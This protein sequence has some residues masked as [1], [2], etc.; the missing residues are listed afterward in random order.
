MNTNKLT[1]YLLTPTGLLAVLVLVLSSS[2]IANGQQI[3]GSIVGTV[4][5][6]LAAAISTATVKATNVAT[7]FT[8]SVPTNGIG[9]YRIDYLPVGTYTVEVTAAGFEKFVQQN[10]LLTVGESLPLNVKLA[11]GAG[12]ANHHGQRSSSRWLI[13]LTR[14]WAEPLSRPRSSVFRLSIAIHTPSFP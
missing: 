9:E 8:R 10:L 3:T 5:D 11:I 4:S 6:Q 1:R 12:I 14:H 2:L 13:R 7:G